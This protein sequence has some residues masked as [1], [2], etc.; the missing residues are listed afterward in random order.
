MPKAIKLLHRVALPFDHPASIALNGDG[1][2]WVADVET[3]E[4]AL[5]D[6]VRGEVL[7][8]LKSVSRRPQTISWDG[9]N[10]WEWDE[11]SCKIFRRNLET[12][13]AQLYGRIGGINSPYLGMT[14]ADDT[15]WLI[16]PDQPFFTV[17]NNVIWQVR[18]PRRIRADS[19]DAPTY[20]C[21]GLCHD[22]SYL[23]TLDVE[24]GEIFAVD[25]STGT[26]LTS[27]TLPE[28]STPSSLVV[29]EDRVHTLDLASGRLLTYE[30]DRS[31][32]YST[33]GGRRSRVDVV[34]TLRNGG[35]G[36]I[37]R[38]E[39]TQSLPQNYVHQ[40]MHGQLRIEPP[41]TR[42][43]ECGWDGGTGRVAVHE[44]RNLEAGQEQ[45]ILVG[46]D[47][48]TVNIKYHLYP[49]LTGSIDDVPDEIRKQFSFEDMLRG[50]DPELAETVRRAQVL[51]QSGA[52]EV[53]QK[54]DE[55]LH[56]ERNAFWI[57]RKL[58]NFVV[59]K[60]KYVLP[61]TSIGTSKIL[62]QGTGSCG[63]HAT[64]FIAMCQA[65]GLP[66]RSIIGFGV[67]RDDSRLGYLDH[68][69]P[70]VY[71]PGYGWI[72]VDT[73]R[74]MS[75]PIYGTQPLTKYRSFGSLSDRFFV[76]GFG[77]D[78]RS[79]FARRKHAEENLVDCE[80][81]VSPEELFFLRWESERVDPWM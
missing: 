14:Y 54:V 19:Y 37:Q 13:R 55:I 24:A 25:P 45:E 8:T 48:E 52:E 11:E 72:P 74:F 5:V 63:N 29:T 67:W 33:S 34:Y 60:V 71:L 23:W 47:V 43:E 75:L 77:R 38:Q 40:R 6:P 16:C 65:A 62:E 56:G 46:L 64:I 18:F 41:P 26:I 10:L 17:S 42:F 79:P 12:G 35:P 30:L 57:A 7:R 9:E 20:A 39:F 22:G 78:L 50:D 3:S 1:N 58:Y 80:G 32:A 2:V 59:E 76:N 61:Y 53:K 68:E 31:V 28:T 73:S 21:R 66:A 44:I 4:L 27:Y 36:V 81:D 51:F 15:L 49:H 70:E 69:I